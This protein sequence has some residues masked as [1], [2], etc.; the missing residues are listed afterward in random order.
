[1]NVLESKLGG[2]WIA[3]ANLV[4]HLSRDEKI[5]TCPA[6]V[7]PLACNLLMRRRQNVPTRARC[8]IAN[9]AGFEV[10][11]RSFH[12]GTLPHFGLRA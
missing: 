8:E 7:P 5:K 1:V 10:D 6:A 3:A 2:G 9:H 4:E 12:G 11:P